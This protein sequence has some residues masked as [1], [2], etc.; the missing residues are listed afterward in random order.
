MER[1]PTCTE[2]STL[3]KFWSLSVYVLMPSLIGLVNSTVPHNPSLLFFLPASTLEEE[4]QKAR[5]T[6]LGVT[7][8]VFLSQLVS[9]QSYCEM[10]SLIQPYLA[11]GTSGRGKET[12]PSSESAPIG[13]DAHQVGSVREKRCD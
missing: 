8:M 11:S 7:Q 2:R 3:P 1:W 6:N 4:T 5:E 9:D 10:L 13:G 12:Q